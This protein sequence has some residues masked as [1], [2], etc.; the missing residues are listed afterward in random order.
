MRAEEVTLLL[1][2]FSIF[3]IM[4]IIPWPQ[5][6]P[7]PARYADASLYVEAG[8]AY[9]TGAP[10]GSINPEHP[11]L[12]KYII[13]AFS[14]FLHNPNLSSV[15]FGFLTACAALMLT[16][17]LTAGSAWS[18][19]VVW[20]LAFDQVNISISIRPMLDIFMIFFGLLGLWLLVSARTNYCSL[21]AGLSLGLAVAC[22]WTGIFFLFPV[23]IFTL[24]ERRPLSAVIELAAA[25]VAYTVTYLQLLRIEGLWG[26]VR[27]QIL[28]IS[29]MSKL[30]VGI[31][32]S[33]LTRVLT[34]VIYHLFTFA[35]ASGCIPDHCSDAVSLLGQPYLSMANTV[36]ALIVLFLFPVLY[37]LAK[38]YGSMFAGRQRTVVLLMLV[39]MSFL[40]YEIINPT[41][42]N[43]W[44]FAPMGTVI[45]IVSPAVL[46]DF[47]KRGRKFK[48]PVYLYLTVLTTWLLYANAIYML[49]KPI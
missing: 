20:I 22:K 37:W 39:L 24:W 27:S 21:S 44:Y 18:T 46:W 6:I 33:L 41:N 2:V 31:H 13:G 26:F 17:K 36:N 16:R 32:T 10:L 12:A 25:I 47:Q 29:Y 40:T 23:L 3:V 45:A 15:S 48:L 49:R 34:P 43:V 35:P 8:T 19:L 7:V 28:I 38:S 11:P 5:W 1:V 9:V 14:V 42:I 30:H 4:R